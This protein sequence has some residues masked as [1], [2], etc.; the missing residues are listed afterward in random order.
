MRVAERVR[1]REIDDDEGQRL[2]RIVRR[3]TG[4]VVTWRRAQMVLLSAQ[5]M[6][7]A[8]IAEVTFTSSDRVR[9]VVHNF[10][11]DGFTSLYPRY[12][13][14]RPRTFTLPE[15]REIKK[16]AKS[17]PVEHGLPFSAW[18]LVKLADFLV[19]EGVVDDI[20]HEGLRILLREEG[21]TFQRLKTWKA[22]KDPDYAVKKARVEHLYAIADGEVLPEPG[23]PEVV[24]CLDQFGPLNLQPH[25][26][27]QWAER[28]GKH[29][30][31]DREPR[32]RRRATYTRPHGVRHLFA[33]YDL[34]KDQLYGHIKK[35]KNRSKFLEFCR[36]LR[37]LHPAGTRIAIICDN[38]SPHLTTK[39][40]QRV[41]TWAEANNVEI[42]Y[43]PTNSS[44]LNRIEAQFTALRYFALDGTDHPTHKTQGSM[45]RRYIIWRNKNA[46]DKRFQALVSRANAA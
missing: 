26:G 21:V 5:G 41:G 22:S 7:V 8:K 39:R 38:Y 44:W 9:D 3:G 45:I 13:G 16:I 36:Y 1:V 10:N 37:S 11:A 43:T 40:C 2:L 28:G 35:T 27:R 18:S 6:D 12:K 42:T 15:R 30:D 24:F 17:R 25:P 23:E 4:S 14:G 33:A 34:G 19:A 20:S 32:R 31:S 46:A 29:K